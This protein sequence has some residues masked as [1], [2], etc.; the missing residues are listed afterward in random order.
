[1][2]K[3]LGCSHVLIVDR[4]RHG[5]DGQG[6]NG[7]HPGAAIAA[8]TCL[9]WKGEQNQRRVNDSAAINASLATIINNA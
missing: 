4:A 9:L 8:V 2:N 6:T 1:M 7:K 5:Q 3:N